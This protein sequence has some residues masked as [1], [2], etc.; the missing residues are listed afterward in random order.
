MNQKEFLDQ[1][2]ESIIS[3]LKEEEKNISYKMC[4]GVV[5]TFEKEGKDRFRFLLNGSEVG[6][7]LRF[8]KNAVSHAFIY[9]K[10]NMHSF[11]RIP[12]YDGIVAIE[13][14]VVLPNKVTWSDVTKIECA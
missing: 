10:T 2:V 12:F 1:N 14:D 11:Q 4:Q 6:K 3:W 8:S 9:I 13:D 7:H 5:I